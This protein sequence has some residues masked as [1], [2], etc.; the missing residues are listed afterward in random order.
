M[1]I[2]IFIAFLLCQTWK[3]E[4]TSLKTFSGSKDSEF[5]IINIV[6]AQKIIGKFMKFWYQMKNTM[7]SQLTIWS[8]WLF[9]SSNCNALLNHSN[10]RSHSQTTFANF[11]NYWPP[12]LQMFTGFYRVFKGKSECG[13]FKF[14][15]IACYSQS[16]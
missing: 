8:K 16:L 15:G 6:S 11:A 12:T 9:F 1:K 2:K 14:M 3:K 4:E 13:D 7:Q 10:T 5:Q